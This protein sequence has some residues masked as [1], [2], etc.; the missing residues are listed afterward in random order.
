MIIGKEGKVIYGCQITFLFDARLRLTQ[1]RLSV[2]IITEHVKY[3]I[4]E[5]LLAI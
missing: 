5:L 1:L 3:L 4:V 2:F